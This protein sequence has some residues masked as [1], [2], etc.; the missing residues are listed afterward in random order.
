MYRRD[1]MTNLGIIVGFYVAAEADLFCYY[2]VILDLDS[3][4]CVLIFRL[5]KLQVNILNLE[6]CEVVVYLVYTRVVSYSSPASR[7]HLAALC[8]VF[9]NLNS[10]I[11]EYLPSFYSSTF[12]TASY[13]LGFPCNSGNMHHMVIGIYSSGLHDIVS[14]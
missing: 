9:S 2:A 3:T 10:R 4:H 6:Q 5:P 7:S 8:I 13:K 14:E 12:S 11:I 1:E